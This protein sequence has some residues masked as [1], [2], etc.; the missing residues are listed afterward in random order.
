MSESDELMA[1]VGS[2]L[3][4]L[5]AMLGG[6]VEAIDWEQVR[7]FRWQRGAGRTGL[8]KALPHGSAI[9]LEDLR[10]ID[11]QKQ[12]LDR[13]TRQ[14]LAGLPANHALLWGPRGTGKSSLIKALIHEHPDVRVVEVA[15]E[16]LVDLFEVFEVLHRRPERFVLFCDDLSFEPRDPSY[17][18]L[19]TALDGSLGGAPDNVLVYATSNR[20]HLVPEPMRDNL[21]ARGEDGELH[22]SE[23]V[24]ER[25]SLSERFGLWLAFHPLRQDQ[26]LEIAAY[27][28]ERLGLSEGDPPA[29]RGEALRWALAHGSRS[30]RSA[31]QFARDRVGQTRLGQEGRA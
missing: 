24:E 16:H 17:R 18:A 3:A 23:A 27:W 21:A 15:R 14:F 25:I 31:F 10:C 7:A 20:R 1:R 2:L 22:H 28:I 4:R 11:R 6:P 8:L 30:G 13:N 29:M 19:K 5:E 26:Y 12:D 9:R